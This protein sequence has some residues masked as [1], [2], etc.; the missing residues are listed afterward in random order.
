MGK[1]SFRLRDCLP[2]AGL[3]ALGLISSAATA[4]EMTVRNDLKWEAAHLLERGDVTEYDRRATELRR[5][6]ERTPA[7]IWKLSLFYKGPDNWP[8]ERPDAPIWARIDTATATYLREHPDSPSAV[9]A[10]AHLLV[11]LAWT[12]RGSGW[13]RDLSDRQRAGFAS[14]L[15]RAR[16]VLDANRKIGAQ[17]PEW[18]ALRIQVMNGLGDD[19]GAILALADEAFDLE[20]TYQPVLYVTSFAMLPKWGGSVQLVDRVVARAIAK[21]SSVEGQQAYGRIMFNIARAEQEPA[22]AL[23]QLGVRW[24]VLKAS[25]SQIS[26]AYP[27]PWNFNVQRAMAC[28]LGT[29]ADLTATLPQVASGRIRV[30]WFDTAT[31]WP[32]CARRQTHAQQ[33]AAPWTQALMRTPPSVSFAAAASAGAV[34]VLA[35]LYIARRRWNDASIPPDIIM[36]AS[37]GSSEFPRTYWVSPGWRVGIS[38]LFGILSLAAIAGA[39]GFGVMAPD[40]RD[41]PQG[42]I[43]V[44][45]MA[46]MA[47]GAIFYLMDNLKSSIVLRPDR[48]EIHE[49]WRVQSIR[50]DD[51]QSRQVLHPPNSPAVLMLQLKGPAARRVKLPLMWVIDGAWMSWFEKIPDVD[52]EAAK[53]FEAAVS[54][55][56]ELG[57]NPEDRQRRLANA[58]RLVRAA[59]WANLGLYAWAFFCPRPYELLIVVL[60]ALPWIAVWIMAQAPGLYAF[61]APRGSAQPDLTVMLLSPGLLLMLRAILDVHMLDWQGPMLWTVVVAIA[62]ITA[63]VWVLPAAR[64]KPGGVALIGV[65][66]LAYGYG[67]SALGNAL[68]DRHPST[69]YTT[70]VTGKH[71]TSGRNRTPELQL[72]A[73]G[74]K[75]AGSQVAVTWDVYRST[76]IGD[77]VCVQLHPGALGVPWYRV[78]KCGQTSN[79]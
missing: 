6:R 50:R 37:S 57:A 17:D 10:H 21:S 22:T 54:D 74:P 1:A 3:V 39:W 24:P 36:S 65:F 48:L 40:M 44:F 41:T 15:E 42:L 73:W 19:K 53:S 46:F 14:Y 31:T 78:A 47:A 56:P 43:L 16:Q 68:L 25:L 9:I 76:G 71:V 20:P 75:E 33:S 52:V 49:I 26:A 18:Y 58:R 29:E 77:T 61:N 32:E 34:L 2:L 38:I 79:P 62:L 66:L 67:A 11:N 23:S 13:S 4:D 70:L 30:A 27:D 72:A 51:I 59:M 35:L 45:F 7:G 5:T 64:K 63:V 55:N 69:S 12:Y 8:A 60:I 28:V